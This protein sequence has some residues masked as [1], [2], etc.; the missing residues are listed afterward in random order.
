[1]RPC[2]SDTYCRSSHGMA[3]KKKDPLSRILFLFTTHPDSILLL[4]LLN[5]PLSLVVP[6]HRLLVSVPRIDARPPSVVDLVL[7]AVVRHER[8]LDV[9]VVELHE[10]P[11]VP[12][13]DPE[14][15]VRI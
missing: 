12:E 8:Q 6:H 10:P 7:A 11:E 14:V 4:R 9:A 13:A 1:M 15:G 2:P 5:D 3:E